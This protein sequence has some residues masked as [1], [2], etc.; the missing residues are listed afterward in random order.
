MNEVN[1]TLQTDMDF[2]PCSSTLPSLRTVR[3]SMRFHPIGRLCY[4]LIAAVLLRTS[5]HSKK[6]TDEPLAMRK[7]AVSG[8]Q[9]NVPEAL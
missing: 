8:L 7:A 5:R 2:L 1:P 3:H 9:K 4:M 6:P